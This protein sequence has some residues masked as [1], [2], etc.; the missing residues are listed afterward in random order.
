LV[1]RES[2]KM[3]PRNSVPFILLLILV[4]AVRVVSG[5]NLLS[6]LGDMMMTGNKNDVK[7]EGNPN[8]K[9]RRLLEEK[10]SDEKYNVD[11]DAATGTVQDNAAKI[12]ATCDGQLASALVQANDLVTIVKEERDEVV[13]DYKSALVK[14]AHLDKVLTQVDR[15]LI[16]EQDVRGA[17]E[18]EM[19][20]ALKVEKERS[21]KELG[22]LKEESIRVLD[23][24]NEKSQEELRL[25]EEGKNLIITS[26]EEKLKMSIEELDLTVNS[27]KK[28]RETKLAEMTATSKDAVENLEHDHDTKVA[29]LTETIQH[30]AKEAAEVLHT[31]KDEAKAYLLK[32]ATSSKDELVQAKVQCD[33]R[34]TEKNEKIKN[35]QAD[36]DAKFTKLRAEMNDAVN[37]LKKDRE[38]KLAEM[39]VTSKDAVENLEHDHDTKVAELTETMQHATEDAAEVLRTTKDE[40]KA[41]L[42]KQATSSKDELAQAKVQCDERLTEKNKKIKNLQDY[43]ENMLVNKLSFERSLTEANSELA[44]WKYIDSTR[45]YCNMTYIANDVYDAS[46]KAYNQALE[47]AIV[48]YAESRK[49][50]TVAVRTA[51]GHISDGF[52]YSSRLVVDQIDT[53]WPTIQ[54]YYN[55]HIIDN[56]ETHIEPH[57]LEHVFPRLHQASVWYQNEAMPLVVQNIEN[58]RNFYDVQVSPLVQKYLKDVKEFHQTTIRSYGFYCRSSLEELRKAS[59]PPPMYFVESLQ[60]SCAHPQASLNALMQGTLLVFTILFHR[61]IIGLLWWIVT[62]LITIIIRFTPLRFVFSRP[63]GNESPATTT[64]LSASVYDSNSNGSSKTKIE[65]KENSQTSGAKKLY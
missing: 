50:V 32:Q 16:K 11:I 48:V 42:L 57:L 56:Y 25:L 1:S 31:T 23:E 22:E 45:S 44:H 38:T 47:T 8:E 17:L 49:H 29:K 33:E 59:Y 5:K 53:H 40:A 13:A 51:G 24:V 4:C 61:R 6:Q 62:F 28:D 3:K 27:L 30:A 64:T 63:D 15:N 65:A 36:Q 43:T 39:T 14:I 26:L 52:E 55:K 19:A 35:L 9:R 60:R 46:G 21:M 58:G 54:P 7:Q 10:G 18:I 34:L 37:S 20:G 2:K 12:G 41:Y